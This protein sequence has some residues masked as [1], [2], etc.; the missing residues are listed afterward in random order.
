MYMYARL[1]NLHL[2]CLLYYYWKK[3]RWSMIRQYR[4]KKKYNCDFCSL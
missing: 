1:I 3:S 4:N 2:T